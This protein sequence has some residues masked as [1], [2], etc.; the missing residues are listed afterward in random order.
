MKL[1]PCDGQ[2]GVEIHDIDLRTVS[3]QEIVACKAAQREHGV[4]FFRDQVLSCEE[5][6]AAAERFGEIVINRFF[7]RVPDHPEIA[8]VR[9]EPHHDTV[10]G[11]DWHTDHS[12][13]Q[14][15]AWGSILYAHE[16]PDSGGDT[17]FIN[18][19]RVYE[20]L[21]DGLKQTLHRLKAHHSSRHAFG[22][23]ADVAGDER[24]HSADQA[25]QD[26]IHPV[27]IA[28]PD[29][30]MPVLYINPDFTTG[31]VGWTAEESAPLLTYLYRIASQEH[32]V[33]RFRWR[34]GSVAFWDNRA[35]WHQAA[36]DYPGQRRLMHRITL[37]GSPLHPAA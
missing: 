11:E 2:F 26:S 8:M 32:N 30:G 35:T 6:I 12:Y 27:V 33:M 19:N 3:D 25:T 37:A 14:A 10:V 7:E 21:S 28:H 29:S 36:N 1:I 5:H 31:F 9:K 4:I 20:S 17:L 34:P 13:D 18:M 22:M 15:P 23:K 16:V 24:F